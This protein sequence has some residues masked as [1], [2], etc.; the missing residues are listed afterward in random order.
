[1]LRNRNMPIADLGSHLSVIG[2]M[3]RLSRWFTRGWTLQELIAP[4]LLRF[5]DSSWNYL[6]NRD[7]ELRGLVSDCTNIDSTIMG[8]PRAL[9]DLS[10]AKRMS[11]MATRQTTRAEDQA[12]CMLGI[13]G[14]HMPLLYGEED[15][16][17]IRLQEELI[18]R[19]HDHSLLIC[20]ASSISFSRRILA[21][22]ARMF[23]GSTRVENDHTFREN[24]PGSPY[25]LTNDGLRINLPL[26]RTNV[27]VQA[28][29]G[30]VYLAVLGCRIGQSS[31]GLVLVRDTRSSHAEALDQIFYICKYDLS[32]HGIVAATEIGSAIVLMLGE[33][34]ITAK[35]HSILIAEPDHQFSKHQSDPS[36]GFCWLRYDL[37]LQYDSASPGLVSEHTIAK[38]R[39]S[40]LPHMI[41]LHRS[42]V[43]EGLAVIKFVLTDNEDFAVAVLLPALHG[44]STKRSGI[45]GMLAVIPANCA[46]D[47]DQFQDF[48]NKLHAR[49][50]LDRMNTFA[51]NVSCGNSVPRPFEREEVL[52]AST[53]VKDQIIELWYKTAVG[54]LKHGQSIITLRIRDDQKPDLGRRRELSDG[55]SECC[56]Q[57]DGERLISGFVR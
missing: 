15:M 53:K 27:E 20:A 6:G 40:V 2:R 51:E 14:V 18:R 12:Y 23:A 25:T 33:I 5:F 21:T 43:S 44:S 34:A 22:S 1:M 17:F 41:Q 11:W 8:N 56:E 48:A 32:G 50:D 35:M 45:Q 39:P 19:Y 9:R 42:S 57:K 10:I 38:N 28:Y 30:V 16:A 24:F 7:S 36:S 4:G 49:E 54:A 37:A 13:F 3:V 46:V 26:I 31:I 52:E 47:N 29:S 55:T